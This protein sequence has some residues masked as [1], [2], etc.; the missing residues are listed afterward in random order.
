MPSKPLGDSSK[1][2]IDTG[3]TS[4]T[5]G[6]RRCDAELEGAEAALGARHASLH[7]TSRGRCELLSYELVTAVPAAKGIRDRVH[8]L[9]QDRHISLK[10]R[11]EIG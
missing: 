4:T 2:R 3:A 11:N 9:R 1:A 8:G 6:R 10:A 5:H 7:R